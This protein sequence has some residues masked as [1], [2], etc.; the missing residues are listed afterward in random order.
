[1]SRIVRIKSDSPANKKYYSKTTDCVV[2]YLTNGI[3]K[4]IFNINCT[5]GLNISD[6]VI[7]A[8]KESKKKLNISADSYNIEKIYFSSTINTPEDV[9]NEYNNSRQ[10]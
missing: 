6:G 10:F 8:H 2:S 1:M 3:S 7:F 4:N 5:F 9:I